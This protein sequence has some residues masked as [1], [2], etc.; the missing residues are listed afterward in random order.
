MNLIKIVGVI[1]EVLKG[2]GRSSQV[3]Q[4]SQVDQSV[5]H[6][7]QSVKSVSQSVS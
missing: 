7:S 6:S 4:V 3:S 1:E 2:V 5:I